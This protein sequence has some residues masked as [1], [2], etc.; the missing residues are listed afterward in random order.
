MKMRLV[1]R[2][3]NGAW[4]LFEKRAVDDGYLLIE[5]AAE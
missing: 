2:W 3:R 1:L 4:R 5:R